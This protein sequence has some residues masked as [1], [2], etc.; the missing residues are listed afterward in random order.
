MST[1]VKP[2]KA[3]IPEIIQS[4]GSFGSW[5]P[6]LGRK[7]LTN[8][9]MPLARHNFPGLV[10]NLNSNEINKFERKQVEKELSEQEKDLLYLF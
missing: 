10:T 7:A 8:V 6:N 5:L 1:D 4:V 3:Q 9:P 2:S